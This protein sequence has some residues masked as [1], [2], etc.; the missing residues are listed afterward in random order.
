MGNQQLMSVP[1]A[2]YSKNINLNVSSV[3]DTLTIGNNSVIVPGISLANQ[4]PIVMGCMNNQ[5]CNYNINANQNDNNCFFIGDNCN[6]G[7]NSTMNDSISIDCDCVGEI[8]SLEMFIGQEFG[9]G[10]IAYIFQPS[11]NGFVDGEVHGIIAAAQDLPGTYI[12]GCSDTLIQGADDR[13]IGMGMQNT[14]DMIN[15]NCGDAAQVCSNLLLNGFDDWF[16]PSQDELQQL[17]LNRTAIGGFVNWVYWSSNE[18]D[19]GQ[20][21]NFYFLNGGYN[22]G[23]KYGN[24]IVRPVRYF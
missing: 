16:L 22:F 12:W 7:N 4:V 2:M 17:Y 3:G 10:K 8:N 15:S 20:A 9:G 11:D 14:I 19:I 24:Y 13:S 1:Y 6:D 23:G 5:A 21:W 18:R